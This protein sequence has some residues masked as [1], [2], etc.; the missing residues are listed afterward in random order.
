MSNSDSVFYP[1]WGCIFHLLSRGEPC[2][3]SEI[4][5]ILTYVSD[6]FNLQVQFIMTQI[7]FGK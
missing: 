4:Y 5:V 7:T 1:K 2:V 6:K 3:K